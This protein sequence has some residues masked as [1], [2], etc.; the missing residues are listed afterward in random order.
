[1]NINNELLK[2]QSYITLEKAALALL[3][4]LIERNMSYPEGPQTVAEVQAEHEYYMMNVIPLQDAAGILED[5]L[6]TTEK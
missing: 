5:S 1:M 2:S 4:E 3:E 6:R